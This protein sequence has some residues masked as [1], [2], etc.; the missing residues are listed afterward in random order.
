MAVVVS[1][2]AAAPARAVP[3]APQQPLR[4]EALDGLRGAAILPVLAYHIC[5]ASGLYR[6]PVL[7]GADRAVLGVAMLGWAG[8]DLFFVLSGFLIT[9]ILLDA[10]GERHYFR[11]FY[12]RRSL[13]IFPLFYAVLLARLCLLPLLACDGLRPLLAHAIGSAEATAYGLYAANVWQCFDVSSRYDL[14]LVVCW[15]LAVE[16]QFY[17]FWPWLVGLASRRVLWAACGVLVGGALLLRV[18]LLLCGG[19]VW[20]AYVL[21]PCR[22]DGFAVGGLLA[23]VARSGGGLRRLRTWALVTAPVTLAAFVAVAY[24]PPTEHDAARLTTAVG[25]TLLSLFSGALLVLALTWRPA[26]RVGRLSLLRTFGRYSYALY[27]FHFPLAVVL[28]APF[29]AGRFR[30]IALAANDD[31]GSQLP[32]LGVFAL[33]VTLT[34][35]AAAWLSWHLYEKHFLKL[36]RFFPMG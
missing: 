33:V 19:P 1:L 25:H 5:A 31:F 2:P 14:T 23:L 32:Y 18:G 36:K 11:N 22:L 7:G 20:W 4:L 30:P 28:A 35:L 6:V 29:F 21:T 24:P 26:A 12:L 34:A 9:G 15:S 27:L 17:F 3:E 8:V 10:R 16:E 13:R